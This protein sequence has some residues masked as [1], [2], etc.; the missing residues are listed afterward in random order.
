[1]AVYT[2]DAEGPLFLNDNA[3]EAYE[4]FV[5]PGYAVLSNYVWFLWGARGNKE[6]KAGDT[7]RLIPPLMRAHGVDNRTL[8]D[9]SR[10]TA[11][12]VPGAEKT[13]NHIQK[14]GMPFSIISTS[15]EHYVKAV[16]DL[17]GFLYKDAYCTSLDLDEFHPT[18][19]ETSRLKEHARYIAT[20]EVP[21]WPFMADSVNDLDG[22][23]A[24]TVTML[25]DIFDEIRNMYVGKLIDKVDPVGGP[26]KVYAIRDFISRN[27]YESMDTVYTGDSI[28]DIDA[29][30]EAGLAISFNGTRQ[31]LK[32][33]KIAIISP[34]T[35]PSSA[36]ADVFKKDG[37][38]GTLN[39]ASEWNDALSRESLE[40][41]GVSPGTARML[42][43]L[44]GNE[45]QPEVGLI[46]QY[47]LNDEFEDLVAR[48][49][50]ARKKVRGSAGT[51]I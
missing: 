19:G 1:M 6:Y 40:D 25:D 43:I 47:H 41:L 49:E 17:T 22:Y 36:V 8:D 3:A 38:F 21:E 46:H 45:I 50:K 23:H 37:F 5:G 9:F 29:F 7:L 13:I 39:F 10:K 44:K 2:T 14:S 48:S 16:S 34:N 33:A 32:E 51:L 4:E 35:L 20:R 28:T 15:Y 27:G 26:G 11:K 24:E 18:R 31:A 12:I 30:K 42:Y